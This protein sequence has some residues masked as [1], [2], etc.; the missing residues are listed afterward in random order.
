VGV[1]H[2]QRDFVKDASHKLRNLITVCRGH[3]ELL[4]DD[5]RQGRRT[6][7]LVIGELDR[8][9]KMV[10][11]MQLLAEAELPDFLRPEG[12]DLEVFTHE[13][14]AKASEL[15]ARRWMLDHAAEGM[16]VADRHRMTE[17]VL[18]LAENAVKNTAAD[19]TIAIG[20]LLD[21]N[22]WRIWVRDTGTGIADSDQARIFDHFARGTDA[23]RRYPGGGLGLT[24]VKA[25]VEAHD[26]RVEIESRLGE[27]SM[28]MIIV[29]RHL[30]EG[31]GRLGRRAIRK[32]YLQVDVDSYPRGARFITSGDIGC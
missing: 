9:A 17:A 12:I 32:S 10:D 4:G 3:L 31:T 29:S 15:A 1:T 20:T 26:G 18:H 24:I 23:H 13:L 21:E 8:M 22:E 6:I 25:I 16:V 5:R 14:T 30:S 28:F 19:D 11:G 2:I 7:A 27:G